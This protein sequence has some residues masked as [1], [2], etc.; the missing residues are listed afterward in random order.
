MTCGVLPARFRRPGLPS[1]LIGLTAHHAFVAFDPIQG[2]LTIA[3][4]AVPVTF[5]P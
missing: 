3:S 2:Q 4:N 1:V 5:T